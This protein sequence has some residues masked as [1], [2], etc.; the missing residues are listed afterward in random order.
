M[1]D[2]LDALGIQSQGLILP[3][4]SRKIRRLFRADRIPQMRRTPGILGQGLHH[5]AID[6]GNLPKDLSHVGQTGQASP[7]P[8]QEPEILSGMRFSHAIDRGADHACTVDCE[9]SLEL[10]KPGFALFRQPQLK[11]DPGRSQSRSS[12][13]WNSWLSW[14]HGGSLICTG[15]KS[16]KKLCAT[17]THRSQAT[18]GEIREETNGGKPAHRMSSHSPYRRM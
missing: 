16:F 17:K 9:P 7:F 6:H 2:C 4:Q 3:S 11:K 5:A 8:G 12:H 10:S 1:E 15:R 18:H 14:R 13:S